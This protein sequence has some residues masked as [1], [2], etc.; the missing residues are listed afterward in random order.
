MKTTTIERIIRHLHETTLACSPTLVRR[1]FYRFRREDGGKE[2]RERMAGKKM[3]GEN[4]GK[5]NGGKEG[6]EIKWRESRAGRK[7]SG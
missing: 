1:G 7:M 4:G 5:E 2:W 6:Q 3:A